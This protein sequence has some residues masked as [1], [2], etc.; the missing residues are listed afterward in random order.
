MK[1]D[2]SMIAIDTN[3]VVRFLIG[4]DPEQAARARRLI[5]TRRV[6]LISTVLLESEWVLRSGYGLERRSVVDK[7]RAFASLP[8]VELDEPDRVA[9]AL[10]WAQGGMDFADALHLA[11]AKDC[12]AFVTFDR[13]LTRTVPAVGAPAVRAP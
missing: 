6:L 9:S 12:E 11:A 2:A 4:D 10:A 1:R 8:N 7:L 13:H 5:E 3:I